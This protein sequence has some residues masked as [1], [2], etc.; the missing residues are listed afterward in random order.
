VGVLTTSLVTGGVVGAGV[1]AWAQLANKALTKNTTTKIDNLAFLIHPPFYCFNMKKS[2]HWNSFLR[3]LS[4]A[5]S[6]P[7]VDDTKM[8]INSPP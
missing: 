7:L 4:I 1:V 3:F 5:P 2:R 8:D 6:F